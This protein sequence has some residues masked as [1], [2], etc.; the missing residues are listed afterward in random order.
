MTVNDRSFIYFCRQLSFTIKDVLNPSLPPPRPP[1]LVPYPG[2]GCGNF[3]GGRGG[4]EVP[5]GKSLGNFAGHF[6]YGPATGG[7]DKAGNWIS[8]NIAN[9][10][11]STNIAGG[12]NIS[13]ISHQYRNPLF[14]NFFAPICS[15]TVK[16]GCF[17]EVF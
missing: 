9:I 2:R 13:Q 8:H 11:I 17:Q 14:L 12:C 15:Y 16:N 6:A 4:S 1:N 7:G 10:A 3:P 5:R